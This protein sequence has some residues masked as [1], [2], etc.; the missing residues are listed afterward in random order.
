MGQKTHP[1]GFRLGIIKPWNSRWYASDRNF[2]DLVYE[3]MMVKRYI[4]RRLDNAGIAKVVISRAP[5][6]VTVDIM[7]SRPGIVI[8]RRGAEVDKLREELQ[9]LTKKDILLNIVEVRKPELDAKLVADSVARQLEG[10]VSFR[11]AMK[12]SLAA[13]MKMGAQ[14]IKIQCGGRLGG[15]EIARV[16]KYMDGRVP[17]HTIRADIDYATS[18]AHTTHGCIGIKVWICRGEVLEKGLFFGTDEDKKAA[19]DHSGGMPGPGR[20]GRD[21]GRGGARKPRPRGRLRRAPGERPA[22]RGRRPDDN[23]GPAPQ[24]RP[25]EG[26][27]P[28][29]KAPA[30]KPA[31][32]ANKPDAEN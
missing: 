19:E 8:G 22:P 14:G 2:A 31:P 30:D 3:D 16:E 4:T 29:P 6:K 26:G 17:L 10:R 32:K 27:A 13:T 20:R 9:L 21:A 5:K 24:G 1:I 11:R 15:A 23:R 7:T 25:A 18:T 28:A 12:K